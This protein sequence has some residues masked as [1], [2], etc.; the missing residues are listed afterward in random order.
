VRFLSLYA[1]IACLHGLLLFL[2]SDVLHLN[3][4]LGFLMATGLQMALS[5]AGNKLLVFSGP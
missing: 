2:W 5:Y 4:S 3:Y 1:A